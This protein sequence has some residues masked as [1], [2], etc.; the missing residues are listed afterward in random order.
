MAHA[1]ALLPTMA[2]CAGK[3]VKKGIRNSKC[4]LLSFYSISD[5]WFTNNGHQGTGYSTSALLN[6]R[7]LVDLQWTRR[8]RLEHISAHHSKWLSLTCMHD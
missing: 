4:V 2:T 7:F 3:A 6:I 1:S 5:S 8:H